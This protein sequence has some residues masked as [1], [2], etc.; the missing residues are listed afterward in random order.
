M[1]T[2]LLG[3]RFRTQTPELSFYLAV[4]ARSR[5]KPPLPPNL[6]GNAVIAAAV[7]EKVDRVLDNEDIEAFSLL[8]R[9]MR[10]AVEDLTPEYTKNL[11]Q[12][13]ERKGKKKGL[14]ATMIWKI[15]RKKN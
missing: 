7:H 11:V 9:Q 2:R 3:S 13:M 8:S 4:D 1:Q 12:W 5:F 6:V 14:S 10:T 15:S